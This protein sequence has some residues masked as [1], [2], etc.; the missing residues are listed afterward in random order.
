MGSASPNQDEELEEE[1]V[2]TE[3]EDGE[4]YFG[5]RTEVAWKKIREAV[6]KAPPAFK[7]WKYG[8]K[9]GSSL[10]EQF[11]RLQVIVK[12]ASIEL[13]PEKPDFPEGGWHVEGQMN[14]HI[15]GTALYY[16][17]SVNV[18][19]SHLQFRMQTSAYQD[20]L[21][22][23]VGQD[24]Y[25]WMQRVYGT[26]LG[27]GSGSCLQNYGAVET[28]QGRVLAFPNVFHHRVSPFELVDK[29]KPGH[30]RFIAI[31][32]VDPLTRIISTAN[33]PPQQQRWWIERAFS[34]LG[35]QNAHNIPNP[36][37]Q[38]MLDKGLHHH[39]LE[40]AVRKGTGLPQELMSIVRDNLKDAFLMSEEEAHKHRLA[41][42]AERTI[43]QDDVRDIWGGVSYSF[44]E[45]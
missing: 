42:M 30:R 5:P 8:V 18:T 24:S 33:V 35:D 22:D 6:Q 36:V 27:L 26:R 25:S 43:A 34:G 37:A 4:S 11:D 29:T 32:L 16:L 39:G 9:D 45:H 14:E 44:C 12:M 41:M 1:E 40:E 28:K 13:T 2:E 19:A 15:V 31:W 7:P 38:V 20:E 17:D 21:Q 23:A 3:D 10:K